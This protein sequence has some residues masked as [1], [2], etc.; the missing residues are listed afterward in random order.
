[1]ANTTVRENLRPYTK[2]EVCRAKQAHR[3]LKCSGYPL[4]DEVMQL[5]TDGNVHE[6]PL[7]IKDDLEQA[8]EVYGMHPEYVRGK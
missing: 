5:K 8:Y 4:A 7:L 3:F 1:V 6:M 2:E